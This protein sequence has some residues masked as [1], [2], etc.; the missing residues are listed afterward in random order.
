ML[1]LFYKWADW[2]SE[3]CSVLSKV[4]LLAIGEILTSKTTPCNTAS[5]VLSID[6]VQKNGVEIRM[7]SCED[8][9]S[10][11]PT[12]SFT[13]KING[14]LDF[15]INTPHHN[16]ELEGEIKGAIHNGVWGRTEAMGLIMERILNSRSRLYLSQ[17]LHSMEQA[18]LYF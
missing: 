11:P 18:H 10:S 7:L 8:P 2:D 16:Y 14:S 12:Q 15:L 17:C 5:E 13:F 1:F 6:Y 9:I 3:R 4:T